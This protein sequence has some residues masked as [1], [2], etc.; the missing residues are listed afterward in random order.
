MFYEMATG[1]RPFK[2]DTAVSTMTSI[3][4]DTPLPITA[5]NGVLPRDLAVI[6][7][8]CL[9]KNPDLRTQ[10]AKD[11]RN[12][13]EDLQH[14][15]N[16]GELLASVASVGG[17]PRRSRSQWAAT[18]GAVVAAALL[19]S[20]GTVFWFL[21]RSPVARSRV[22]RLHITPPS[23]AALSINGVTSD[24]TITPDGSRVI[25]VGAKGTTLFVRPL[26]QLEAT[27]I[28]RGT[29]L[30]DPFVS[31]DGQWVGFFDGP[32]VLK[33]VALTGGPAVLVAHLDSP[34]RGATWAGDG[35]IIF[36]TAAT[37]TG[38]QRVS[39]DG[40]TPT[41]LTRPDRGRGEANHW[42]PE[43]LPGGRAVLFTVTAPT[44]GF[45]AGS[46]A[47]LELQSGRLTTLLRGGS[48]AQYVASGHL[49]YATP[50]T[51]HVVGFDA[52]RLSVI[53]M[54][55]TVVQQVQTTSVGT[56]EARLAR[57]GTL[58][59]VAGHGTSTSAST[60]VWVDREGHETSLGAPPRTYR[61]PR[62]SPDGTRLAVSVNLPDQI[63]GIW[64]WDLARTTLTRLTSN[65]AGDQTPV[66][67]PDGRRL[68]FASNREGVQ[69]LFGRAADGTGAAER[70]TESPNLQ[71]PSAVSP[72]GTRLVFTEQSPKTGTD[73]MA[74]RL[75]DTQR[76]VFP[77]VQTPFEE[78]NGIVSPNGRLLAYEANDTGTFEVYVRPF[79]DVNSGHWQVSTNGGTQPAWAGD[80]Q[81]LFYV[82]SDAALMR[83][84]VTGGSVWKASAPSKVLEVRYGIDAINLFRRN[85]DIAPDGRRFLMIKPASSD[86][87]G[88]PPQ[89]VVVQHFD[90]ELKR[91]VPVK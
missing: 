83:V 42:W 65:P 30:R 36:A 37:A 49:V 43:V 33:K 60:P 8:R 47:D 17:R 56:V 38:L 32:L 22:S 16:A 91:L 15:M 59:Y 52:A 9:V 84:A 3:L 53:G 40:G 7:R 54:P 66:W 2:G 55:A 75:D 11:L 79:P 50:D 73:V 45:D 70:L 10:S 71:F 62:L 1:E 21:G 80:G 81:E 69:N 24:I 77:L 74:L 89:I 28:V 85:Y 34:E 6:V 48:H 35:T 44:G 46:L 5:V 58:V 76:Q 63:G 13:L 41:V 57:D 61:E 64:I 26:D 82:A 51:L 23:T 12:Q 31:P 19:A 4:R 86:G 88:G 67:T 20:S 68:V 27:T 39:A 14:A 78:R 72:D 90:E 29:A 87:T 25:Y 18:G